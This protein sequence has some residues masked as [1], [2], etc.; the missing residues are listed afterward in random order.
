MTSE[1]Q[2]ISKENIRNL[3]I[4]AH[5]DHGKS[6]LAD[7]LL[8]LT[9][10]VE[11][12]K[13]KEQYL[14]QLAQEREHGI[15]IKLA[16]ASLMWQGKYL[17]NLIDTPG[18]SDFAYEVSRSLRAVEGAILLVDATKGVQAQTLS[19]FKA[20]Q[21]A[22]LVVLPVLNKID[23]DTARVEEVSAQVRNLIGLDREPLQIS[24]KTGEGVPELLEAIVTELPAPAS[25]DTETGSKALIFDSFY[26]QYW[27]VKVSIR[28]FGGALQ[29]GQKMEL[30]NTG[31][32]LTAK[33]LGVFTPLEK[34]LSEL[35]TNLVGWMATGLKDPREVPVG[36][37]V[38]AKN[39]EVEPL[40]GFKVPESKVFADFFPVEA[41]NFS[42]LSKG[43]EE[44]RLNDPALYIHSVQNEIFGRGLQVGALGKLHLQ[45]IEE[46]LSESLGFEIISTPPTVG[47]KALDESGAEVKITNPSR[48][49]QEKFYELQ[50]PWIDLQV[51]TPSDYLGGVMNLLEQARYEDIAV[52]NLDELSAQNML[53]KAQVPLADTFLTNFYDQLKSATQGYASADYQIIGYFPADLHLMEVLL[54]GE[55][56]P[57]LSRLVSQKQGEHQAHE[58]A[59]K[60]KETLPRQ[61]FSVAVQVRLTPVSNMPDGKGKVV[62]REDLPALKKNVT[63]GLYGGDFSRKK[64]LLQK[65]KEG[66]KKMKEHGQI[67]LPRETYKQI[68][69]Q[70]S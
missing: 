69:N 42:A 23:Q 11:E 68:F 48:L 51:T 58:L 40:P 12:R 56:V 52:E 49:R 66:Q 61:V 17:L 62:A 59:G 41:K 31:K 6:T 37:T 16:P 28:I 38:R 4:I 7:R 22:G 20:A 10:S 29:E 45:I 24:A 70:L 36:E 55:E 9:D 54:A 65:Q 44:L 43:L 25:G 53:V 2:N 33:K 18:H 32:E 34:E 30:A 60:L 64:K 19:N 47:Y 13:M 15:T 67:Q 21:E 50:E 35:G 26:D 3:T 14:D 63:A 39:S 8:E 57:A 46:R 27:G 5:I 1:L